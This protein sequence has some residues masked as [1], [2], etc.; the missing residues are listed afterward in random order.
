MIKYFLV[1]PLVLIA[2]APINGFSASAPNSTVNAIFDEVPS[3]LNHGF[4][5]VYKW[6]GIDR[7]D[8]FIYD[9]KSNPGNHVCEQLANAWDT[10]H[11]VW[12]NTPFQPGLYDIQKNPNLQIVM[13]FFFPMHAFPHMGMT[14]GGIMMNDPV[15]SDNLFEGQIMID[16]IAPSKISGS[17]QGKGTKI[18]SGIGVPKDMVYTYHAQANGPFFAEPCP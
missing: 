5:K 14:V 15:F 9:E 10:H 8:I 6:N 17:I 3:V 11:R 16:S 18:F 2:L 13:E 4:F 7:V 1:L 12:I